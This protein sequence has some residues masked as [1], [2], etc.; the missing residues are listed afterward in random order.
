MADELTP[1]QAKQEREKVSKELWSEEGKPSEEEGGQEQVLEPAPKAEEKKGEEAHDPWAGV[2]PALRQEFET[3]QAKVK[4]A[5]ALAERLKQAERRIGSITNQ[6]HEATEVAK[7]AKKEGDD[8]PTKE[9]IDAAAED[10]EEWQALKEDFPEWAVAIDK[11]LASKT[12]EIADLKTKIATIEQG[13]GNAQ[14]L[15]QR[16][17]KTLVSIQHPGWEETVKTTEFTDWIVQQSKE[18]QEKCGSWNPLHAIEILDK[19]ESRENGGTPQLT[20]AQIAANRKKRLNAAQNPSGNRV[21]QPAKNPDD[22]TDEEYRQQAA[23]EVWAE[24]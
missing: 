24:T 23:R 6:L 11:R 13:G 7:T 4:D 1:E 22:M 8:A 16:L 14:E 10:A 9:Q 2:N 19:F 21:R 15:E 12:N 5:D 18:D 3:L 17:S 20:A